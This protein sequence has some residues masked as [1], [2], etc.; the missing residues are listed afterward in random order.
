[1]FKFGKKNWTLWIYW[2]RPNECLNFKVWLWFYRCGTATDADMMIADVE[3]LFVQTRTFY[4]VTRILGITLDYTKEL[5][6][7]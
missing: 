3:N 6:I 4:S 2:V 7:N 5:K 1:M